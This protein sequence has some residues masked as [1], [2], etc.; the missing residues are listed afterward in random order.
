MVGIVGHVW[1]LLGSRARG[2]AGT[3]VPPP[4]CPPSLREGCVV[5]PHVQG[6]VTRLGV[7]GGGLLSSEGRKSR[8]ARDACGPVVPGPRI[9]APES[10]RSLDAVTC[11]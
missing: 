11:G 3:T 4:N 1:D 8:L 6:V 9:S 5:G 10:R 7:A 2:R